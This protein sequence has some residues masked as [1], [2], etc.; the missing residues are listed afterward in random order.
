VL[1]SQSGVNLAA[2]RTVKLSPVLITSLFRKTCTTLRSSGL[3]SACQ[4]THTHRAPPLSFGDGRACFSR[5]IVKDPL[6]DPD[7]LSLRQDCPTLASVAGTCSFLDS[8]NA[9]ATGSFCRNRA[10]SI[11][12]ITA[13]SPGI[14]CAC[15]SPRY[16]DCR[17]A[18]RAPAGHSSV[19]GERPLES[20][21]IELARRQTSEDPGHAPGTSTRRDAGSSGAGVKPK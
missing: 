2:L 21:Q 12:L 4:R 20:K 18:E 16:A 15:S 11:P 7:I 17:R 19:A 3:A 9:S 14:P 13:F 6:H 1:F 5:R 10:P 8:M